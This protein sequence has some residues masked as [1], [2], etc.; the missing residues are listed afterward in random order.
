LASKEVFEFLRTLRTL[1]ADR[2][3]Q[4]ERLAGAYLGNRDSLEP[5]TR[6]ELAR[7]LKRGNDIV[8][9][10]VRPPEE[11]A[12]G[13]LPGAVSVPLAELRR[14]LKELPR[15]KEIVAYCRG[16]YCAFSHVAVEILT[17]R[18]YRARRL[19][20]GMPEWEAEARPIVREG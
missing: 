17:K 11:F 18:G 12:A 4:V 1:A 10:D 7:R 3:A 2:L 15:D 5:V 14:R 6:D 13:H 19:E 20:E 16:P 8:V 9:L